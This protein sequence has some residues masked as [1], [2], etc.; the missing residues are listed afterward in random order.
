MLSPRPPE[1]L[2]RHGRHR[3]RL[4]RIMCQPE[5]DGEFFLVLRPDAAAGR[6]NEVLLRLAL[7]R[8]DSRAMLGDFL[9]QLLQ[10]VFGNDD[11]R[12]SALVAPSE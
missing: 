6:L 11:A 5:N 2:L 12:P 8:E 7:V 4:F 3:Q 1:V 10:Q 9:A